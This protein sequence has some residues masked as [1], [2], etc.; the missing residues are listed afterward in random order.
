MSTS[1][2]LNQW[3]KRVPIYLYSSNGAGIN[4][5]AGM[6]Q[7]RLKLQGPIYCDNP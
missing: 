3:V 7:G 1:Q 5:W 4:Y 2:P 6:V